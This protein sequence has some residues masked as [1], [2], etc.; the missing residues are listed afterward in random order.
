MGH[1]NKDEA[2]R[3]LRSCRQEAGL[4]QHGLAE[5]AG[6][7]IG[8]VRDLEQGRTSRLQE[9]SIVMLARALGLPGPKEEEFVR[10]LRGARPC[11][12]PFRASANGSGL[13]PQAVSGFW[14]RVLGSLQAWRDG[15]WIELGPPGQRAVLGLL[16]LSPDKLVSREAIIDALWG[17]HPPITAVSLVQAYVSRLRRI[18]DPGGG[19]REPQAMLVSA[20]TGYCLRLRY[21]ELDLLA[22]RAMTGAAETASRSD[23]AR[24]CDLYDEALRL[25]QGEPLADVR[26][27]RSHPALG[28]LLR[29]FR[30]T[31]IDQAQTACGAGLHQRSLAWLEDLIIRE[32]FDEKAHAHLM[33]ALAGSGEQAAALR[34]YEDLRQRLDEQLGLLPGPELRDAYQRILR[35]EMTA[36]PRPPRSGRV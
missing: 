26:I 21:D 3:L 7:S 9:R 34:V 31:I 24:A 18:L 22:F 15:T 5:T 20:A 28:S 30:A 8:V 1:Q 25:W 27:L 14:L 6:V 23:P 32:P 16:A 10:T 17:E 11:R 19:A 13:P 29:Q 33:I 35:Q 36:A 12:Q 4:S 2:A